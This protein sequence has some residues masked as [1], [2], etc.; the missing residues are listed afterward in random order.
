MNDEDEDEDEDGDDELEFISSSCQAAS[1]ISN[2][3]TSELVFVS[4]FLLS[5]PCC[6]SGGQNLEIYEW[7][8]TQVVRINLTVFFHCT[9]MFGF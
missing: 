9:F 4:G 3:K 8:V 1:K 5:I 7:T 6:G 2:S